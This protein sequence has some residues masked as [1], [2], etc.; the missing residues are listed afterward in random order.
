MEQMCEGV[1][2]GKYG[3]ADFADQQGAFDAVWRK[4]ALYKLRKAG[5]TN[6]LL[7]VFSSFLTDKL[8]S[9]LVNSYASDWAWGLPLVFLRDLFL[10]PLCS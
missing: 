3:I 4:G 9:N 7:S 10:T 5:I 8:Y 2:S 6:N 1:A